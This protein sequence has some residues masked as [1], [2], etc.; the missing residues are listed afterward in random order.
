MRTI[1]VVL[2]F[3]SHAL[4]A[5]S[6]EEELARSIE[7]A[8]IANDVHAVVKNFDRV[9]F[10]ER[11]RKGL[12]GDDAEWEVFY[13]TNQIDLLLGELCC[14]WAGDGNFRFLRMLPRDK[15]ARAL[16]RYNGATGLSHYEILIDNTAAGLRAIDIRKGLNGE[17]E[18]QDIQDIDLLTLQSTNPRTFNHLCR[19]NADLQHRVKVRAAVADLQSLL[20]ARDYAN[21]VE[22]FH[23]LPASIKKKKLVLLL[24]LNA[25]TWIDKKESSDAFN[26]FQRHFANDPLL[27]MYKINVAMQEKNIEAA[28][29]AIDFYDSLVG[30][31]PYFDLMRANALEECGRAKDAI[32][33]AK[34]V[35]EALPEMQLSH[36]ALLHAYVS[37]NDFPNAV[38]ALRG[39]ESRFQ[40]NM[41]RIVNNPKFANFV[42]SQPFQEW[43]KNR[44]QA[45]DKKSAP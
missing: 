11:I 19:T 32:P 41:P 44:K 7:K 17:L 9:Q 23:Q 37:A 34:K 6:P 4:F 22:T 39:Y 27:E 33:F 15:H 25:A 40:L 29:K 1:I 36:V 28:L 30:G 5:A 26:D 12:N 3:T 13:K 35:V 38:L 24:R 18:S 31:D 20:L 14:T 2:I 21:V 10:V 43:F 16:F 42:A 45:P 8:A